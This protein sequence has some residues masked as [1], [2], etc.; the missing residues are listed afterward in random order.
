MFSFFVYRIFTMIS[1]VLLC[2]YVGEKERERVTKSPWFM[3]WHEQLK[4]RLFFP[5]SNAMHAWLF[6]RNA[7]LSF[8][9]LAKMNTQNCVIL[10]YLMIFFPFRVTPQN[11]LKFF[12]LKYYIPEW[13]SLFLRKSSLSK[14]TRKKNNQCTTTYQGCPCKQS[15]KEQ[16]NNYQLTEMFYIFFI[17]KNLIWY[18]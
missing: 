4:K 2:K 1:I 11:S 13:V 8:F 5:L 10:F 12:N 16:L 6:C 3:S 7:V 14:I 18:P 15:K 17:N 9:P